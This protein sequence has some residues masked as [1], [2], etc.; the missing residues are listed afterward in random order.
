MRYDWD[1]RE[2]L[3][4]KEIFTIADSKTYIN[5]GKTFINLSTVN[6][7]QIEKT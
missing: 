7:F 6:V 3:I 1:A 4:Q 2:N 5:I